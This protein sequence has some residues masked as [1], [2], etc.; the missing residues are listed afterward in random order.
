MPEGW[1]WDATL[2]AGSA[3]FY[4]RGR[5]PYAPGLADSLTDALALD[6]HGRLLDVGC[7]P[8]VLTLVLAPRVAL[9]V[10]VDPDAGMLTEAKAR[11]TAATIANAV[12]VQAR[13]EQ[14]PVGTGTFRVATFGQSFHWLD[15]A[16]VAATMLAILEPGGAFVHVS[17]V[18]EPLTTVPETDHPPPPFDAIGTLIRRYLG[19]EPRAGQG[20]LRHGSPSGEAAI[21]NEAGFVDPRRLRVPHSRAFTRTADDLVAWVY[22]RSNSAPHLFGDRRPAFEAELRHLLHDVSPTGHF[23]EWAPDTDVM[24]WR[25]P[26]R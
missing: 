6:G 22:S 26:R 4:A 13:A 3:P 21:L 2:Y 14:L 17:E 5:L 12:W 1:T 15:R 24:I 23:V 8:G 10:G 16:R 25:T 11:A 7:G 18:K 9:A 19:A 20:V